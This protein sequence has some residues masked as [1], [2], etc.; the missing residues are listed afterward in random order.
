MSRFSIAAAILA[1]F[2]AAL[3]C[4]QT[5][6]DPSTLTGKVMCGYQ[7][8]FACEGDGSQL[9]W[10]HWARD[11]RQPFAPGNATVDLWP[12]VSELSAEARFE[13]GFQ[14]KNGE[15]AHVFS[16]NN[17][18][19][20]TLHFQWMRDYGIDGAFLQ[21]FA[22]GLKDPRLK[23]HKDAV[24]GHVREAARLHG[25]TYAVMYDLSGLAKGRVQRVEADW[26]E[27]RANLRLTND[28]GYLH[29]ETKPLVAVWG[30]GF[31]DDRPYT[32]EECAQLVAFLKADGCAVM[33][34]V[35]SWWRDGTRDAVDDP[36]LREIIAR[37][38]VV[39]PWSVGRYANPAQAA[40]HAQEVWK[41]DLAWCRERKI[42]F[43]PVVFPGF[44]WHNL[45]GGELAAIPRLKGRFLQAQFDAALEIGAQMIYVAMFD[46]VD[47][48]TA[49]F[50]CAND[51]PVGED[52]RFLGYEGLPADHY[53]RLTGDAA[54]RLKDAAA[55]SANSGD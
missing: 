17:R 50:K 33:L 8:W 30:I 5:P 40:K 51:V 34:G 53:L 43:L 36:E 3:T 49:I 12:D 52:V 15:P 16:S 46:E 13:T 7:G 6:A 27:L 32:L 35:P 29:H 22:N 23:Q 18:E 38:D 19:T 14:L 44:S 41:P 31:S 11:R 1:V 42:D 21:R 20:V 9:G 54:R 45:K 48:G 37:A 10:V 24:L 4:G 39:G 25:R 26:R 47:E 55:K 28:A 2:S